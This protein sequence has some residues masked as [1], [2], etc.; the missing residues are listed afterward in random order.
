MR[1]ILLEEYP[2][3]Q[4]FK[5]ALDI[6]QPEPH[7]TFIQLFKIRLRN[8]ASVMV[9]ADIQFGAAQVLGKVDKTGVAVLEDIVHQFLDNA[10]NDQLLVRVKAVA[11]IMETAAGVHAAGPADLLEKVVDSRFKPEILERGGHKA[12]GDITD[13]LDRIVDDLLGIVDAL[14]LGG[15]VE[16]HQIFVQVQAGGGQQ[17]AGIVVEVGCNTLPLLFLEPDGGVQ[18]HFL[19]FLLHPLEL[20]LVADHLPLMEDDEN[21]Q[22]DCQGQHSHGAEEQ[23]QGDRAAGATNLQKEHGSV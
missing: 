4:Q 23:D 9:H 2:A 8:A 12:M 21:D 22:P 15:L 20:H 6:L 14:Q 13:Q 17:G 1:H 11:V 19:L 10:E 18:Q 3:M 16:V 5:T 7:I